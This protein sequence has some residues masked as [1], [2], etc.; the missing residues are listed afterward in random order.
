MA[1]WWRP[2]DFVV[3]GASDRSTTIAMTIAPA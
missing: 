3:V 1:N 2:A